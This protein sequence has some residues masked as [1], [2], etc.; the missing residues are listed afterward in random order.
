MTNCEKCDTHNNCSKEGC[1]KVAY[2]TF[3]FY[4]VDHLTLCEDCFI[5]M[6]KFW[7]MVFLGDE[8]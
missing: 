2:I 3:K 8:T 6:R 5:K 1:N 7:K 4:R